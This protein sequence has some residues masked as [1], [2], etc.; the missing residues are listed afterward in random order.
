MTESLQSRPPKRAARLGGFLY[1]VII[2]AG[3]FSEGYV[4]GNLIVAG[5]AAATAHN[6]L[7]SQLL[8]RL[9]GAAEFVTLSCDIAVALI[10]YMLLRPVNRDLALLAAFFR[11]VFT[12]VYATLSLTHFAPLLLLSSAGAAFTPAQLQA[13]SVF[14]LKLHN[15]G[16]NVSLVFFGFHCLLIGWLI[17]RSGLLPRAIGGLLAIAGACYLVNSFAGVTVPGFASMLFPWILLPGF[18]A[19]LCLALWLLI[20]GFSEAR[21][22]HLASRPAG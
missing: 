12:A 9:G 15:L 14:A 10:L 16:Y 22:R 21:W 20:F 17:A 18:V 8:Y 13:M 3:F 2:A 4:R 1:L 19:E 5:N 6:I 7:G 11:L